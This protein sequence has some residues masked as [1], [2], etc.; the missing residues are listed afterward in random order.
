M[1]S[2]LIIHVAFLAVF[3]SLSACVSQNSVASDVL[4]IPHVNLKREAF[5]RYQN[6]AQACQ[7]EI[8]QMYKTKVDVRNKN[9]DFREC[10]I[11]KGYVLL[12]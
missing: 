1:H 9:I 7:Q 6:D 10:L 8:I 4:Q 3:A 2:K 11:K 12:S 5:K